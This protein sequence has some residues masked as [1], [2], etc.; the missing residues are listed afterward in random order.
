MC[1]STLTVEVTNNHM[2]RTPDQRTYSSGNYD[3]Y[4]FTQCYVSVGLP[5]G[6]DFA[7]EKCNDGVATFHNM[8]GGTYKIAVFDQWNDIML[9]G[10]VSSVT[11]KGDVTKDLPVTQWRTNLSTRTYID[12]NGNGIPDRDAQ[13]NDLEA[14]LALVNTNI[15]YRDGSFGFFN[16]TDLNGYAG[17]N[18][19][20]P[21][22]N[23]LV[24]ETS[25]TRFK[26]TG[27]HTVYD[28]GG[29]PDGTGV[30]G[31]GTS[32]IASHL[33]NTVEKVALPAAQRVPGAVYCSDADCIANNF[34]TGNAAGGPGGTS[35]AV[36][37]P[38]PW[39]VSQ[40]WQ[41]LLGQDSFIEF[42]MKPF[43]ENENGGING[44]VI[45]ASTRPFDDPS[46][47]LQLSW[48]PGVPRVQIN[49]YSKSTDEFGNE[50]LTLV[51]TTKS[52][53]WDDWA[54]GFR[55]DAAGN[56]LKDASGKYIPNMNCPGQDSTSPF[57]AT[58]AGSKEWLDP[59]NLDPANPG[60]LPLAS[61]AQFKCY[62][63]W[64]QLN[65]I[66]PAPYDGM[67]AFPSVTRIDPATGKA[68]GTNC[69]ACVPNPDQSDP[70]RAGTPM[71]PPGKYVVEVVVPPGY[72][73][74]KEEDKN[75]LLG[76]V[77]IAPVTQQFA[78]FGNIFI[79][80]DQ[81]TVNAHYNAN[82]P[83]NLNL[84]D[85]LGSVT[86]PRHEGDTG[87]IESYWPCVGAKR[88]VPD[89]NS[90][91]PG[92]GQAAP[93]AGALRNLC[94]R[95][96]VVLQ[97][98]ASVLAKFYVFSSTHIAGHFTGT[99]TNDFASEFDPFSPQ[100]GEKFGPP[101]L[102]VGLRDFN[103]N[104]VARV[105]SDQWGIY[106]GLYFSSWSVNPPNPTGYAPQMS[107]ACM[108]DPG[109]IPDPSGAIDPATGT[110]RMITDPSYNPAYS[111]FCYE[112][113]FMPG[114]TAYMDTPVIPTMA[115]ADNYNLPDTEYPDHTPA[116]QKV[117]GD[118]G[119]GPWVAGSSGN[120]VAAVNLGNAGA[121]YT[122]VPTVA[123]SGNGGASATAVLKP[124]SVAAL[125]RG[126][127]GSGYTGV[128]AVLISGTGSGASATATMRVATAT[129]TNGG[130]GTYTSATP[131][132]TVS[133]S[134]PPCTIN[135]STC[136]Q[137]T[138]TV[139]LVGIGNA[140][141]RVGGV[142]INNPGAGYTAP[143]T[144]TFSRGSA[145]ANATLGVAT[146]TLTSGGSGY[147]AVP[148]VSIQGDGTGATATASLAPTSVASVNLTSVGSGY[149][150]APTVTISGGG[151]AGATATATLAP[152]G[153][154]TI[155]ALGEQTVINPNFSG[156][157]STTFPYN[158]KTITRHYTFG[159]TQGSVALVDANGVAHP[160][161][162]VQ[163]SDSTITGTVPA[164]LPN[165]S[166]TNSAY[167]GANAN[168]KCGQLVI[169]TADG[170]RSIDTV[171]VTVGGS[172]PWVV[173]PAGVS[174]PAGKSV[175]DYGS[176]FGRMGPSP[177]QVAID[178]ASPGDLII[179]APG[180]YRENLIMWK[181]VRLQGVGAAAVTVNADAHPAGKMDQWRRQVDCVFG[182]DLEGIPNPKNMTFDSS[183]QYS[184]PA[185]M[186]QRV[187]RIQFEAITGWDASGN[188][189]L[190]QVLQEPTLMGAY[191]GA[192]V[193]VLGRGIRIPAGS[194]D[195]WGADPTAAGAFPTGSVYIGTNECSTAS[196]TGVDGLDY[197]TANF[198]CNPSRIDGVSII[199]SSQGGGGMF[200]HGW[201]QHL[202]VANNRISGNH[203]TLAG[204][205]N[206]GNGE[207]PNVYVNDGTICGV[208]VVTADTC[209]PI[210]V[211]SRVP[212]SA[213]P[214]QWN[215]NVRIHHNMIHNNASIGDALFTGTPAGA[216]GI[217]VSAGAD[218][219]S[220]D[221]N[222]IAGNLSTGDGG[223]VQQLGVSFN[224]RI[225]NNYVLFNQST[226]PTLP[227]NGGGIVIEGAN[228]P[229]MLNG[230]ECGGSTDSDCP[231]GLGEG[232]G[233]GLVIDAN[234]ILGNSAESGSG[235]GLRL[236]QINGAEVVNFP[237]L[238][239]QWYGVD[240]TNNIIANNVAGWDGGGVSLQDALKVNF[241]NNTVTA[242]DTTASAG[243]LFKTLGALNSNAPASGCSP[244]TDPNA[245][246]PPGCVGPDAPHGPQPSGLVTMAHTPN[247]LD[248]L[249]PA[250]GVNA[251]VCPANYGY[252]VLAQECKKLSKPLMVNN[253]FWQ[254]RSFHV[255]IT[256]AKGTGNKSQQA[257]IGLTPLLNQTFTGDCT[258]TGA[259][260]NFYWDI[261]L[262]TDD[263]VAGLLT[264]GNKLTVLNS[265]FTNDQQGV[266]TASGTNRSQDPA[267]VAPFCNGARIPPE[268]CASQ[269][270]QTTQASCKGYNTPVGASET[271]STTELFVFN[272]IQPTATV[273]EGHNWLNLTFGP[274]TLSRPGVST[275][276][277][278]E[279]LVADA[280]AGVPN[281]AY[282]ILSGSPAA[283]GGTAAANGASAPAKDFFG[284]TR[285]AAV[286]IGAVQPVP[287]PIVTGGPLDFGKQVVGTTSAAR[288]LTLRN[289]GATAMSG[290]NVVVV[291]PFS[292][293]VGADGGT[294]GSTL[295]VA[296]TCTVNVVFTPIATGA[297]T[298]SVTVTSNVI[299]GASPV[300]L[301]GVG[302]PLPV[303]PALGVLDNF[304]RAA[305]GTLGANW[306]QAAL[307]GVAGIGV[308]DTTANSTSTGV[309][310]G[311]VGGN[312]YW[313]VPNS[314]FGAKQAA[315]VTVA[316]NTVNGDGLILKASGNVVLGVA[317]NFIRVR[318]TGTQVVVESSVNNGIQITAVAS[319]A[320]TLSSG[321]TLTALADSDGMVYVWKTSG[322]VTSYL[323][324]AQTTF[325][326][327]GRIGLQLPAGA[328]VDNFAGGTVP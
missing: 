204:G 17:F 292:R 182:L 76:D 34:K 90:L 93:F 225:A 128:P 134:P 102:P 258:A 198:Y 3:H 180:T 54:Q 145:T 261:G 84:T 6:I 189:N 251:V 199:N 46:L 216:G 26:P 288:T 275:A 28:A 107:I 227:T 304:N 324:S 100:F 88:V 313:N 69:S 86:F 79:M 71:L 183:G 205:I 77:Y 215:T 9:D 200:I 294:C 228:E 61:D 138:G 144:L 32:T 316:N 81:A 270:S 289:L 21:F 305:A 20:F 109:P 267:F 263:L 277:P 156:P 60:K 151:G 13:G 5:D 230:T 252:N 297:A 104:E 91:F 108:N 113:P 310:N 229:R 49:L 136:V 312:A 19:V 193:T 282:S 146:L 314:G 117:V 238:S 57:F 325:T 62:D 264:T 209:P 296:A 103:G 309:A 217:T 279:T 298:G 245:P 153:S 45:Y 130:Q 172:A 74:V 220:I 173:T 12:A 291:G 80:P 98:Q 249:T 326:G 85:H 147:T 281:G 250:N 257:I 140:N 221:H 218:G 65:Q 328:R 25:S 78:G 179:V 39:G 52:T 63:G 23:W 197:G 10:L 73:L 244:P 122:S 35:G 322:T 194:T 124:T 234:L 105:Y 283:T 4:A 207:T 2:S 315:A 306:S 243:S 40:G 295:A 192:G 149:T 24:V 165:C 214:F 201:A 259:P 8:P 280:S 318:A 58:L 150:N 67:Y 311:S 75:I 219:Y 236:S 41:G 247:L 125:A 116:I 308:V 163:W 169:T 188:G 273:D 186:H 137:A 56:L 276:T 121:N 191:E 99:I 55:R 255:E 167:T 51:D 176:N 166:G 300:S 132:V 157:N 37:P 320:G 184:C 231:P 106:N 223:G 170:K 242:N 148:T 42:G 224:A 203:G 27:I 241:V 72:E 248:A 290:I 181:P 301:T 152:T 22:M 254:N 256:Q 272:G 95:K 196:T 11:I 206:L 123:F 161:V 142:T 89:F 171:T 110:V 226:N 7:F 210:P 53:S 233:Q 323:G 302:M 262:R 68:A 50:K 274:L 14:G 285:S 213:I 38:Q 115:F 18:E 66:Q 287:T 237:L 174:P 195:F 160:L 299:V 187:D 127:T 286:A 59:G 162:G 178:S 232:T 284:T 97:D 119:I 70:L 202:E 64:S 33:A 114:F 82:N 319:F 131:A 240:V 141:R 44:H 143:P 120:V 30:A 16:N 155:T 265:I 164:D 246:I 303:L 118:G 278:A 139:T 47:S 327:V 159:A 112:T 321:D 133:F 177:I 211:A 239:S 235:G 317:Q 253:L 96:E 111:N 101:N 1:N 271:T 212:N 83:G 307:F 94:D 158:Q 43:A 260:A 268:N 126:A 208:G 87:S 135:G 168:A 185:A 29:P 92:A 175:R 48:E 190:A 36:M 129:V 222:W 31:A 269:G 266:I 15:R 154:L 293:P